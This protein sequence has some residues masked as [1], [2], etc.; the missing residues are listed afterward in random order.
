[1]DV[2][3]ELIGVE[4]ASGELMGRVGTVRG[5]RGESDPVLAGQRAIGGEQCDRAHRTGLDLD[6]L[7]HV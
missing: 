1:M 2:V 4:E 7:A 5:P 3:D 6:Q